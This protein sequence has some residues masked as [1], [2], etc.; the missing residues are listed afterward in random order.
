MRLDKFDHAILNVVQRDNQLTH[1]EIGS[2]VGLSNSAIRR[3]LKLLREQG[4]IARD[5]SLLARDSHGVTVI[6]DVTFALDTPKAYADFD[7]KMHEDPMVKQV[8]HVSG[9]TDYVLIVQGPSLEW[10]ETWAKEALMS[11][12]NLQ[13][14][15]TRVV[16]SCK[17]FETSRE[18]E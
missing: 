18:L 14:H 6:I 13:R 2:E 17:K 8:Y 1:A 10:Y 4:I 15:D 5:V 9:T 16:Y 7:Q 12:E 11:D 3:R